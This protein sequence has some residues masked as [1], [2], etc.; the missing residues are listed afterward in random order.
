MR[1]WPT[2]ELT[3]I[4]SALIC[5]FAY[6]NDKETVK[7]SKNCRSQFSKKPLLILNR[8][9]KIPI[10]AQKPSLKLP[11]SAAQRKALWEKFNSN[12]DEYAE[13]LK[14]PKNPKL[15]EKFFKD[16]KPIVL[17]MLNA[18][19]ISPNISYQTIKE[20][21][22]PIVKGIDIHFIKRKGYKSAVAPETAKPTPAQPN[23]K[24]TGQQP[25]KI[26]SLTDSQLIEEAFKLERAIFAI[27]E[28]AEQ[29]KHN[30]KQIS[31]V[32]QIISNLE[33][34]LI[35]IQTLDT[36]KPTKWQNYKN[37][38]SNLQEEL[39]LIIAQEKTR[40]LQ[41]LLEQPSLL[42]A[43]HNY[44]IDFPNGESYQIQFNKKVVTALTSLNEKQI[45][46]IL[47]KITK[48][49]VGGQK[50]TGIRIL[51]QNASS[52]SKYKSNLLEI[53]T[54]GDTTGYIRIGGFK[55]ERK[56]TFVH[57]IQESEHSKA[58]A[59]QNF[60]ETIHQLYLKDES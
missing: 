7:L 10:S 18:K 27:L 46:H 44:F 37:R 51:H 33:Q 42:L 54:L 45:K 12:P 47:G 40:T 50:Q 43:D 57:I 24:T 30:L 13:Q 5:C 6:S 23:N 14:L 58:T 39:N 31:K 29:T 11:P 28:H 1:R 55:K 16:I 48:G 49:F 15:R 35:E 56:I 8:D 4:L 38:I 26:E 19:A 53:K 17:T 52:K 59:K 3:L 60:K 41:Q 2:K 9:S 32:N 21:Y 34:A 36:A 20:N 25:N 22:E